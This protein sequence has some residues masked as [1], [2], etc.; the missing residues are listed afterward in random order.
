M[1]TSRRAFTVALCAAIVLSGALSGTA[2]AEPKLAVKLMRG[3]GPFSVPATHGDERAVYEVFVENQASTYPQVGDTLTCATSTKDWFYVPSEAD[4]SY[5]WLR[6]GTAIPGATEKTYVVGSEDEGKAIQCEVTGTNPEAANVLAFGTATIVSG[7]DTLT[8]VTTANAVGTLASGSSTVSGLKQAAG[9]ATMTAGSKILTELSGELTGVAVAGQAITGAGIPAETTIAA[10]GYNDIHNRAI[11]YI[12]LS[13]AATATASGVSVAVTTLG[14]G[15]LQTGSNTVTEVSTSSRFLQG[16]TITGAGIPGGARIVAVKGET[17][18]L[19]EQ[20]TAS[21]SGV[22]LSATLLPAP[23][24]IVGQAVSGEGIPAGTT[25]TSVGVDTI[26]LSNSV[27]A[28]GVHGIVGGVQPFAVGQTVRGPGIP[29]ETTIT[30]VKGQSVTMSA[31]AT[32]AATGGQIYGVKIASHNAVAVS[33]PPAVVAP[34]GSPPPPAPTQDPR[35]V[36]SRPR[37]TGALLGFEIALESEPRVCTPPSDWTTGTTFTYRWLRNGA[38]IGGATSSEYAPNEAEDKYAEIQCEVFAENAGGVAASV[39]NA[40]SWSEKSGYASTYLLQEDPNNNSVGRVPST[41]FSSTT[42]GPVSLDIELPGGLETFAYSAGGDGW[43]CVKQSPTGETHASVTCTRSD[44]LPPQSSYPGI[45]LVE[46]P[47]RDAPDTLLTT[48]TVSGGGTLEPGFAEDEIDVGPAGVFGFGSF[49]ADVLDAA[50]ESYAQAGGHPFSAGAAFTFN[51]HVASAHNTTNG[52][53]NGWYKTYGSVREIRTDLPPGF[54]GNAVALPAHCQTVGE[55]IALPAECPAASAV[56]G[57]TLETSKGLFEDLAIFAMEPEYGAPVQFAFGVATFKLAYTLTARLRPQEAYAI[58]LVSTPAPKDPE[59]FGASVTMC[60]FGAKLRTS[61]VNEQTEFAGC[62]HAGQAGANALAMLTNPTRCAGGAPVTR[63]FADS[64]DAAGAFTEA[65]YEDSPLT[66]CEEIPFEPKISNEPTSKLADAPTGLDVGLSMPTEGLEDP[67][68]IA[69][70][71]LDN[72]T[73]KLPAGMAVNPALAGGLQAC[74]EAQVGMSGGVPNSD[75]VRCPEAS[76]IGTV[77]VKTPLL[78]DI[79][80]GNVYV[81]QENANPFKSLLALY[82]A[83]G[84]RRDGLLLKVA[85]KVTPDPVTGQLTASFTNNPDAPFTWVKLHFA[86]GQRASLVN[87]PSC[88]RYRFQSA[89]SPWTA[90]DP[91]KPT[92]AETV[93]QA[94]TF[95]VARG[96]DGGACPAGGLEAS[97]SAGVASPIAGSSSSFTLD[98][99]RPDGSQRL[100]ALDVTLPPGL[101]GR[102]TGVPFCPEATIASISTVEGTGAR[103]LAS[104]SCPAASLLGSV[105]VAVGAGSSPFVVNGGRAYLAG[106]YEGAPFSIVIVT[107]AVAGPFDLGT[108]VVRSGLYIDPT[109]ARI[110]VKSDPIPTILDGLLL[111]VRDISVNIDRPRFMLA[112][113]DCEPMALTATV[114][115]AAGA[116]AT[117]SNRFQVGG[118]ANLA[119]KPLFKASTSGKTSRKDGASLHVRLAYPKDAL[120][121]DVNIAKVKV[122]LPKQLPSRL[123]TLQKACL[124]ATFDSNPAVCPP[125]SR[126]GMARAIT[127]ILPVPLEGPAY[128]VSYGGAKFPELVVVLQGYGVTIDLHG[129]TFIEH[130]ITSSTFRT[131]PDQPVESFEL[132][133]PQGPYSALAANGNLCKI[134]RIVTKRKRVTVTRT[135]HKQQIVRHVRKRLP[136]QLRMPTLFVAQNGMTIHRNTPIAVTGCTRHKAGHVH[137]NRHHNTHGHGRHGTRHG[138]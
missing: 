77:E 68:G 55:A 33:L 50:G 122:D 3:S 23:P 129:E 85:G 53:Q 43:T 99:S 66:G 102:L 51:R 88:G 45:E 121:R 91:S 56:G 59:L 57:I 70:A 69:Q 82:L 111:D 137:K 15:T 22:S 46:R 133:L 96:P 78:G 74:S 38:P 84:S 83:F 5:R 80:T 106:P 26:G 67:Q 13:N 90:A 123:P 89:L 37:V 118:C 104:S 39:S 127:P 34:V 17:L 6:N 29:P 79:L 25:I 98:L 117:L 18:T 8:N 130:G 114:H 110:T 100:R 4:F 10:F 65:A 40:V 49:S 76:K 132:T 93:D 92:A 71:A 63:L 101:T 21:G 48:A 9:T 136:S 54:I 109:T 125:A 36:E 61:E 64:W 138:K 60:G 116:T 47:G 81:A 62:R 27:S 86:S 113:T 72:V 75:P 120:G 1:I 107:P 131:V 19:S 42:S 94:S 126:V 7:S 58:R 44:P 16:Q 103:E 52:D 32:A 31:N 20:A 24:F 124:A 30:E 28:G 14:S 41:S 2:A 108:V 12:E 73:V 135:G 112:P 87:P 119:F 95:Q 35:K 105:S 128:F 97:L 134:T 11:P 115:G